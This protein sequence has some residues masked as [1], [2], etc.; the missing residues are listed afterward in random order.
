MDE[1]EKLE[2]NSL[3]TSNKLLEVEL[4]LKEKELED[5]SKSKWSRPA[6]IVA[7]ASLVLG[8]FGGQEI[9]SYEETKLRGEVVVLKSQRTILNEEIDKK[10]LYIG[11]LTTK[12]DG[13][14]SSIKDIKNSLKI[15]KT[16]LDNISKEV[17]TK[18]GIVLT[19]EQKIEEA[20]I[21][22]DG[23][24]SKYSEEYLRQNT[25]NKALNSDAQKTRAR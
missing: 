3:R 8:F 14:K 10:N 12:E 6:I 24:K 22:L 13:L 18:K 19:Y 4:S 7:I 25:T 11:E 20:R 15:K 23:L 5:S 9:A 16:E 21:R 1:I 2:L 17:E